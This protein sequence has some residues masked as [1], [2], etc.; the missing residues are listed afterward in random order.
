MFQTGRTL[1]IFL[2]VFFAIS[3]LLAYQVAVH[4]EEDRQKEK[5]NSEARIIIKQVESIRYELPKNQVKVVKACSGEIVHEEETD[6]PLARIALFLKPQTG[7]MKIIEASVEPLDHPFFGKGKISTYAYDDLNRLAIEESGIMAEHGT[8]RGLKFFD[9]QNAESK[10]ETLLEESTELC[11]SKNISEAQFDI[12]AERFRDL[13]EKEAQAYISLDLY[14]ERADTQL[15]VVYEVDGH[16]Y[17]ETL[18][19]DLRHS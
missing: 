3:I 17:Q 11:L 18:A 4:L 14:I 7:E 13:L 12:E 5:I 15:K 1:A 19:M 6:R 9:S 16:L 10:Y 8:L 2:G